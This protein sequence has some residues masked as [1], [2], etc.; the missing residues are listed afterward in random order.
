[1]KET[2]IFLQD[3]N[4]IGCVADPFVC[5]TAAGDCHVLRRAM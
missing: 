2:V 4:A 3:L 5:L 1:M